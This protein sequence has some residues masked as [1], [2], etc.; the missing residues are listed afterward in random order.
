MTIN[1]KLA[2]I[3]CGKMAQAIIHGLLNS[4]A[5]SA[6]N[7][8]LTARSQATRD[9]LTSIFP[10]STIISDNE[11]ACQEADLIVLG[12]K[13][14]MMPEL[15]KKLKD[16]IKEK[17]VISIAAGLKIKS[18]LSWLDTKSVIRL[19]PNTPLTVGLG[20]SAYCLSPETPQNDKD[21]CEAIFT[22]CG[23]V[24]EVQ[25]PQMDAVTALSGSGP[26]YIFELIDS[27][28][29]SSVKNGL[30]HETSTRLACQ[31]LIGAAE[32]VKTGIDTAINLKKAVTSPNGTTEAALNQMDEDQFRTIVDRFLNK[33][34]ERSI[35]LGQ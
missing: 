16:S 3:G 8:I 26:A 15:C 28:V 12:V 22:T 18:F 30:S 13:P 20:A 21:T 31:T 1:K 4:Q 29:E 9:K 11:Q 7:L 25:E 6:Q 33:A 17:T 32:M 24:E 23:I 35:E 2:F 10:D 19:M 5:T 27:M 14:Q 34:V